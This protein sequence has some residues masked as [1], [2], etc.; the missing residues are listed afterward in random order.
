MLRSG[1]TSRIVFCYMKKIFVGVVALL[2]IGGGVY[3]Y[4]SFAP[5]SGR[6]YKNA[7][8]TIDSEKVML[9]NGVAESEIAPGAA[10]KRV[11]K[12]VGNGVVHDLNGDGKNDVVF[13]L[14]QETGGSGTFYYVV[15]AIAAED[16]YS[17]SEAVFIGD[18]IS[19]QK[20]AR[21]ED[22]SVVV[23]YLDRAEHEAF[24]VPPSIQKSI[25]LMFGTSSLQFREM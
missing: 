1:A 16:G 19:P 24:S 12:Y 10:S 9:V 14:T 17:G 13:F 5:S 23:N 8:Y 20:I 6:D 2:I 11:T 22:E 15:A 7:T 3:A 4:K 25:R 21:G 18:R